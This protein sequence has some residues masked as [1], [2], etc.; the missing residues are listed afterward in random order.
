MHDENYESDLGADTSARG[1]RELVCVMGLGFVG[2]AMALAVSRAVTSDG[3]PIFDVHGVDLPTEEGVK[4]VEAINNGRFPF[5]TGDKQLTTSAEQA[6]A[7]ANLSAGID[8][9][10][11]SKA[12]IVIVDVH[13]DAKLVDDKPVVSFDSFEKAIRTLGRY[14]SPTALIIIETTVPPGTCKDLV[15]PILREEF[16]KRD[17]NMD[18]LGLAHSYER[19]MPG[20]NYLASITDYW[21]V[22]AGMDERSSER[23]GNFLSRIIDVQT[24][25]LRRLQHPT[26]SEMAKLLENTY[27]AVNIAL[28]DEWSILAESMNVDLFEVVNAIRDRPTHKNIMRPGLGVGGY[29]LTKDPVMALFAN[30]NLEAAPRSEFGLTKMALSINAE[31]PNRNAERFERALDHVVSG[32]SVLMLGAAYRPEVGDTRFS[33]SEQFYRALVAKGAHLTVHDPFVEYW[34]ELD[35]VPE[36]SM[37]SAEKFDAVVFCV[38]HRFYLDFDV[39]KWLGDARPTIYDCDQVLDKATLNALADCGL[40]LWATGRGNYPK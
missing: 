7:S 16:E 10:I 36:A 4:R 33:A 37:P 40:V 25:P 32:Q 8:P 14:V 21:R 31:M 19:V 27:R 6:L 20:E 2:A 35:I 26:A 3:V 18:E 15:W 24:Y 23:C 22:Y 17:V 38:G 28:I 5:V 39:L 34:Q 30:M 13:L 1:G 29:C 11:Y 9:E 12:D